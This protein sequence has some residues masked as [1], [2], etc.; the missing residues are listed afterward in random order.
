MATDEESTEEKT[1]EKDDELLG[2][3]DFV[4]DP[5][6]K[7][8][9]RTSMTPEL[10]RRKNLEAQRRGMVAAGAGVAGELGQFLIGL[11]TL[12]DPSV[13]EARR[14][15]AQ[16]K[17]DM[18]KGPDLLT[19]EEIAARRQ[20]AMAPVER[21]AEALQQRTEK[22]AASTGKFDAASLLAAG[23][24]AIGQ[25]RQVSLDTEAKIAAEQVARDQLKKKEDA[26]RQKR[27]DSINAMLLN[28]RNENIRRPLMRIAEKGAKLTGKGLAYA[29]AK[30]ID[31]QVDNL[32]R[33]KV[34]PDEIAEVD[35]LLA[36][37]PKKGRKRL[38]ELTEM[39]AEGPPKTD[40][41]KTVA[42]EKEAA[43]VDVGFKRADEYWAN[44]KSG[45]GDDF[46]AW[47]RENYPDEVLVAGDTKEARQANLDASGP[48]DSKAF[49]DAWNKYG[50]EYLKKET[51]PTVTEPKFTVEQIK[52]AI[53]NQ[54]IKPLG[55][56]AFE[57]DRGLYAPVDSDD[58]L[59][60]WIP[61]KQ[62]FRLVERE[63][64]KT[65]D[66][67]PMDEMRN[68]KSGEYAHNL[69]ML[70]QTEGLAEG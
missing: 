57:A 43:E 42:P 68:A 15:K 26:L 36:T 1:E 40:E 16:L 11:S 20:A 24:A 14:D 46:R 7:R 51:Q 49:E 60:L 63:S 32:R 31:T 67:V 50:E 38:K 39:Y 35:R 53:R 25:I 29:G 41:P 2:V 64:R 3:D 23:D 30:G 37:N 59:V 19:D 48:V 61:D 54:D 4:Y 44:N 21:R 62:E 56:E 52:A 22:I 10:Y 6:S 55:F 18:A 45:D 70:V 17:A 47:A 33:L 13:V 28:L 69:Y 5:K 65:I 8:F 66:T 27:I 58:F 12:K 34:P 9:L